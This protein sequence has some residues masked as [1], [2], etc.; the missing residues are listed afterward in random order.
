MINTKIIH[1]KMQELRDKPIWSD[2]ELIEPSV[3]EFHEIL[4]W[5]ELRLL[6]YQMLVQSTLEHLSGEFADQADQER[7]ARQEYYKESQE[8]DNGP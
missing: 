5:I 1:E 4:D 8:E 2:T 6:R 7:K 3:Q